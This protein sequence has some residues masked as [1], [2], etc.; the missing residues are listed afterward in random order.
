MVL[1]GL[2]LVFAVGCFGGVMIEVVH[3]WE[4][5]K[6]SPI[7]VY[8]RS[9]FYWAIST[10]MVLCGGVLTVLILGA[11]HVAAIQAIQAGA[12][13]PAILHKLSAAAQPPDAAPAPQAEHA[14]MA[15]ASPPAAGTRR[16]RVRRAAHR[17]TTEIWH[18]LSGR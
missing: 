16:V 10:L 8:L 9:P 6:T 4:L 12:G 15:G 2:L 11:N 18:I 13:A 7:P 1:E 3:L 5:K 14:P 17:A